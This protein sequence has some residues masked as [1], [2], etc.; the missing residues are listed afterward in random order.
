MYFEFDGILK[1]AVDSSKGH[2]QTVRHSI[3]ALWV[4]G[5]MWPRLRRVR[6]NGKTSRDVIGLS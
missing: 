2:R 6:I 4:F 1:Y 5:M 3:K